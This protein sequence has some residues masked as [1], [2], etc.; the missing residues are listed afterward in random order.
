ME[1]N[2]SH[3]CFF[4]VLAAS[5]ADL[6]DSSTKSFYQKNVK[7]ELNKKRLGL[8]CFMV[9][10]WKNCIVIVVIGRGR[11]VV[12]IVFLGTLP[13]IALTLVRGSVIN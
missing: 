4:R 1:R 5:I 13:L 3:R 12:F 8:I 9:E 11:G 10:V 6:E 7:S 2:V